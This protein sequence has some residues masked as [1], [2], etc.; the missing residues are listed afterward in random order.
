M[1]L[2]GNRIGNFDEL[3]CLG[4][5]GGLDFCVSLTSFQKSNIGWMQQPLTERASDISKKVDFP[6]SIP[7]KGT[8][9]G[10]FGARIRKFF[11]EIGL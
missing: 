10:H 6:R 5:S 9:I 11:E 2:R 4:A 3:W 8:D 1:A 7:Q